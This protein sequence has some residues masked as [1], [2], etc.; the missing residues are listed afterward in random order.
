MHRDNSFCKD[1]LWHGDMEQSHGI[2]SWNTIVTLYF[3]CAVIDRL[4]CKISSNAWHIIILSFEK[5]VISENRGL[6]L[7]CCLYYYLIH[8]SMWSQCAAWV[9]LWLDKK[10]SSWSSWLTG[11][12]LRRWAGD[13]HICRVDSPHVGSPEA[14]LAPTWCTV[15]GQRQTLAGPCQSPESRV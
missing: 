10:T 8:V 6:S 4:I 12:V 14:P 3:I 2:K 1:S 5:H 9:K 11:E 13:G 15:T 7:T